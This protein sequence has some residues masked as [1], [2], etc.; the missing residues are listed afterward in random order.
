MTSCGRKNTV[1]V[2]ETYPNNQTKIYKKV[3]TY[4]RYGKKNEILRGKKIYK[5]YYE[6]GTLKKYERSRD[7]MYVWQMI[8][9]RGQH[10]LFKNYN[11]QGQLLIKVR[12]SEEDQ[13]IWEYKNGKLISKRIIE[14]GKMYFVEK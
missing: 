5:E 2:N 4:R 1:I 11:E 8:E 6:N 12:K 14:D 13:T 10:I 7:R 3:V 9:S